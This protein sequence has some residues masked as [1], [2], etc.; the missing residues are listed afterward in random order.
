[1]TAQPADEGERRSPLASKPTNRPRSRGLSFREM[2]QSEPR[3]IYCSRASE[4][5]EHMPPRSMFKGKA[6][7]R[8]L[9]FGACRLCNNGTSSADLLAA[10]IAKMEAFPGPKSWRQSEMLQHR[11][12]LGKAVPGLMIELLRPNKLTR[13][14]A[15]SPAG[16]LLPTVAVDADGPLVRSLLA[17]FSSKLGMAL[18][19]EHVGSSLPLNG[20][21]MSQHFL[22]AGLAADSAASY[23][24]ML[25]MLGGLSQ[26]SFRVPEQFTYRFNCDGEGLF[27]AL[28]SLHEGLHIF[29]LAAI[30]RRLYIDDL[31]WPHSYITAPGEVEKWMPTRAFQRGRLWSAPSAWALRRL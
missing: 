27:A 15:R 7:P 23:L 4:Q 6:R 16:I 14:L 25:P 29:V 21:V 12:T 22:N 3:C 10:F 28:I 9:E 13:G 18:Y 31:K 20:A 19:R 5:I 2:V 1:M 8:G 17:C 30:D 26:G 11:D 24:S